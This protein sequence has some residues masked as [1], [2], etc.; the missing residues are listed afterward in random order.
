[1]EIKTCE[2]YVLN[3]LE[4]AQEELA[5]KGKSLKDLLNNY[6]ELLVKYGELL[7]TLLQFKDSL[8]LEKRRDDDQIWVRGFFVD[9]EDPLWNLLVEWI[10]TKDSSIATENEE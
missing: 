8:C 10:S 3:E 7:K 5:L 1:M 9:K 4:K 6:G 2:Q